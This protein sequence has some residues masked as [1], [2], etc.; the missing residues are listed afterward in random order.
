LF[1]VEAGVPT[2]RP[3]G[4]HA[5]YLDAGAMLPHFPRERF[6]AQA[7]AIALYLTG[8]VRAAEVGS[9][10]FGDSAR[11]SDQRSGGVNLAVAGS[12]NGRV[13]LATEEYAKD[14]SELIVIRL[15]RTG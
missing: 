10:M 5:V 12:S 8:G 3:P 1:Y 15:L 4:G 2:V 6:P 11:R 7:L 13:L 14:Y 9:L